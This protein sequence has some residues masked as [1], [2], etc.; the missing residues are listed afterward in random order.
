MRAIIAI[1]GG[2]SYMNLV[3]LSD[4]HGGSQKVH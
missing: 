4:A 2:G 1:S 3:A